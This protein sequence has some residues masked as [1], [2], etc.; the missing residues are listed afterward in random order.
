MITRRRLLQ[1]A[2]AFVALPSLEALPLSTT[3]PG[4]R[5]LVAI[6]VPLGLYAHALFPEDPAHTGLDT[7]YL[8]PF[9]PFHDRMTLIS[10][11]YHPG[12]ANGHVST[13]R[14]FTGAPNLGDVD[15]KL[16]K[17]TESFD[18]TAARHLGHLTRFGSLT[19]S[20]GNQPHS[21]Q[22]NGMA[23]PAYSRMDDVFK[24]LFTADAAGD[25]ASLRSR[26]ATKGSVLDAVMAQARTLHPSLSSSDREKLDEYF[27]AIRETEKR[28]TKENTWL[29]T[30]KPKA[31]RPRPSEDL[32]PNSIV[33]DI[34]NLLDLTHLALE[35]DSTRIVACDLF[36][37]GNVG[38]DGVNNG[39]H[40]LSHHGQ[41]PENIRQLKLIESALLA[42]IRHFIE[43]LANTRETDGTSLLDHTCVVLVSNLGNASSHSSQDLPALVF[44]GGLNHRGHLH[45]TPANTTPLS[46]LYLT[47]L[48][49]MGVKEERFATSTGPLKQLV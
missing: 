1:S 37:Q 47:V 4:R 23:V 34:R 8:A 41:D 9:Q 17:N 33:A 15:P 36:R 35:T 30:P 3:T 24:K 6:N 12:V 18:Q 2:G 32:A 49:S 26:L 31:E 21:W 42:E 28:V 29:D 14:I 40:N 27:H 20:M 10:G 22:A 7:E 48:Q 43:K 5:C 44:G 25:V 39:Y 38:L 19:L 45:F 13:P 11:A 46:N 16:A